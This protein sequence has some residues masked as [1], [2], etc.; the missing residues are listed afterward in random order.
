[1]NLHNEAHWKLLIM[2]LEAPKSYM[3]SCQEISQEISCVHKKGRVVGQPCDQA[4]DQI[5]WMNQFVA[6]L[7][8]L[9]IQN[10]GRVLKPELKIK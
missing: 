1:M 4:M 10:F 7:H 8:I 5:D 9:G 3:E 2:S 6:L